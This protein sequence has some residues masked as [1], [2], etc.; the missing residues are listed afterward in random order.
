LLYP[1]DVKISAITIILS[2]SLRKRVVESLYQF[3][4]IIDTNQ[5]S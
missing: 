4:Q 1:C 5:A 3:M 2:A